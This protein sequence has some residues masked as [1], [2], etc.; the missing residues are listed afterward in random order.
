MEQYII[1]DIS[2]NDLPDILRIENETHIS[3]W[4][5][6]AFE[7]SLKSGH[8]CR[9][10]CFADKIVGFHISS[11]VL[12]EMHILNIV[13]SSA[14]QGQG[15][16]HCLLQDIIELADK[17]NCRKIFLEVR[18]SNDKALS[19]YKKWGF[20]QIS[21]RKE[22]YKTRQNT[23]EHALIFVRKLDDY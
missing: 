22:Y 21:M 17:R 16:A 5:Y 1:R 3:P 12:D 2:E 14:F 23:K 15:Y 4:S 19:L 11:H 9:V 7:Q 8:L 10:C 18:E 13:V 20:E 6:D